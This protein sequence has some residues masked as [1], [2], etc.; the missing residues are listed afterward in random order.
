MYN[1]EHYIRRH[2]YTW[3]RLFIV[4]LWKSKCS[5]L[6]IDFNY[7]YS[8]IQFSWIFEY[9]TTTNYFSVYLYSLFH[10][11]VVDYIKV[12]SINPFGVSG[13]C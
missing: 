4:L 13:W 1:A 5:W 6:S 9:S 12:E 11:I 10:F 7:F 8:F 2:W 3:K